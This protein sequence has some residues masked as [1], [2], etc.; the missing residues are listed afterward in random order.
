MLLEE[1][2]GLRLQC[3]KVY[4]G[5]PAL[6]LV[7]GPSEEPILFGRGPVLHGHRDGIP[8]GRRISRFPREVREVF[9]RPTPST[10]STYSTRLTLPTLFAY[11]AHFA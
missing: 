7:E 8:D 10:R 11:F 3:R 5:L 6:Y 1:A 4:R 9:S 2:H